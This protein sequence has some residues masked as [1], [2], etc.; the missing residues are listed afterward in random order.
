MIEIASLEEL[1]ETQREAAAHILVR[2]LAP[3]PSAYRTLKEARK[4][5]DSFAG[6][7][8]RLGF[9]ALD[10]NAVRGWIGAIRTYDH[11][12]EL[13]P[14]AVDPDYARGGIGTQLVRMVEETA[15]AQNICTLYVGTDDEFGGTNVFSK[16]LYPDVSAHMRRLAP[17]RGHPFV[18]YRKLGFSV[19]GLLPDVNGPGKP[20]IFM[21]KR[22]S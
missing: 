7:P 8:E 19:V 11:G 15:R 22:M 12:W 4:E 14:L 20:D 1:T 2:A 16:D 6:N 10:G 21:A 9:A 17:A 13:H 3:W 18:F 5:V